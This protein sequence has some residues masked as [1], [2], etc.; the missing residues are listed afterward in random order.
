LD[1][2][3]LVR[4]YCWAFFLG[5]LNVKLARCAPLFAVLI[6]CCSIASARSAEKVDFSRDVLPILS[7][8]CFRCHG[9]DEK[10]RQAELRL[11]ERDSAIAKRDDLPAITPGNA[12][13]SALIARIT[14]NDDAVRMPPPKA[15]GKLSAEQIDV[16]RR[17]IDQ[18]AVYSEHWAF[19]P[20]ERPPLPNLENAA[21]AK[22]PVDRFVLAKI[23][24]QHLQPA[25]PASREVLIRRATL[26]LTGLPPAPE[27]VA[28]FL[29]D[30]SPEAFAHL[31]DR[32]LAS[33]HY[34]ERW[35][36]HWLDVARYA[37]SGG[38]ETDIFNGHA[39]RFRDYVIRS[40][41]ADKPFDR[42]IREQVA[43]DELYPDDVDARLATSFFTIGPVL[44]ESGMVPGKLEY[45]QLTDAADTTGSAFLGLTMGCAR[46][47]DHKYDPISQREYYGLQAIFAD[48]DQYDEK[49]DG[50][51]L[52]GR[53]AIK[54]TLTEFEI[55]QLK[56][57]ARHETDPA[58]R[59]ELVRKVGDY[60]LAKAGGGGGKKMRGSQKTGSSE[61]QASLQKY[62]DAVEKHTADDND[63]A[64]AV[65]AE[66]QKEFDDLLVEI[67]Q[68]VLD[69]EQR[70][71][72][73][74]QS[75]RA[76]TEETEQ[77]NF[78]LALGRKKTIDEP[79]AQARV[80]PGATGSASVPPDVSKNTGRASG[81]Q[82]TTP[83]DTE[84]PAEIVD[85]R[86]ATG[87]KYLAD[88]SEIPLRLLA[89][90]E[91]P[92]EVHRL[93]H[94]D[95]DQPAEL[96]E[97]CL[98]AKIAADQK[99][100]NFPAD[101]RRAALAGWLASDRNPLTARVIVNR[102][103][104]WHFGQGLVRTPNDFGL[105]G[106]R[107]THPELLDWLATDFI[108][109]GW[110]IKHLHRMIMLSS[111]YQM[112]ST[113]DGK[114]L[115]ADPEKRL[116]TRYQPHR[117]E[118]E[119]VW[120]S[121]RAAAGTLNTAMYGLPVAPPL[122]NQEQIG[123]FRKWPTSTPEEA[124]RR[125]IYILV[126][127]S[128]RFPTLGA[129]DLP[130]N[131]SSCPQRDI[132][133]VPNQALTMLNNRTVEEQAQKF[134]ERLLR[135][136]GQEPEAVVDLAW[137][138][139]Y[140]RSITADERE[141]TVDFLRAHTGNSSTKSGDAMKPAVEELCLALFNTNEFIYMP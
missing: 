101:H 12:D 119:V 3:R 52:R 35:G 26:D 54:N 21:W 136:A 25:G 38:F 127:R 137:K 1:N 129:F 111:T 17:W 55:E 71:S 5:G 131:I 11:D 138:Y 74:R 33:P 60:Y 105:R 73:I 30:K 53:V 32:L 63:V 18:G 41:N 64:D 67:G 87:E 23:E 140:G 49:S 58:K 130:D 43:G 128:F 98:P 122:D 10:A 57:H 76:L 75:Y 22:S 89:H 109:H 2:R 141:K 121:V 92:L 61:L 90:R 126:R 132:T 102:V 91:K 45:D 139:I 7:T 62:R 50:T 95:L 78:L 115:T 37:D 69:G 24:Q 66:R 80:A 83:A 56:D 39:W 72:T 15:A 100:D 40:F 116:L 29:D 70:S 125:A 27:E 16:L 113:T 134:A 110:S 88:E 36:R 48:S 34:G 42:F 77:R 4:L 44:Q 85:Q 20:P 47:H 97:P 107:P 19:V 46:C 133:T 31:V 81:T 123:N 93:L 82:H 106:E 59:D 14:S 79:A 28:N 65:V 108:E 6:V 51:V 120:D 124:N 103:W 8:N 84:K 13:R 112:S 117:V 114:T 94:G 68:R 118:A 86:L 9:Q 104:L 96:I 135:E 99:L